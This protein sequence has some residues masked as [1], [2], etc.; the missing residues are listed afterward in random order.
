MRR[1]ALAVALMAACSD[2]GPATAPDQELGG[3]FELIDAGEIVDAAFLD[4][5]SDEDRAAIREAIRSAIAEIRGG[6]HGYTRAPASTSCGWPRPGTW[7]HGVDSTS[8][9]TTSSSPPAPSLS[10]PTRSRR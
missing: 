5:L 6:R 8:R 7:E 2:G 3:G 9:P 4:D 1:L 10:S